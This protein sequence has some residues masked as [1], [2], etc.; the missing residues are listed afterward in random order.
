LCH[1]FR[2]QINPVSL[3]TLG[4][5]NERA[6]LNSQRLDEKVL[7]VLLKLRVNPIREDRQIPELLVGLDIPRLN[8]CTTTIVIRS[9]ISNA[10]VN[11]RLDFRRRGTRLASAKLGSSTIR[12]IRMNRD[13][14][15]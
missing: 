1:Y 11:Y 10:L 12:N 13:I 14:N 4:R 9:D 7:N 6:A 3:A 8:V 15:V 2:L 5:H